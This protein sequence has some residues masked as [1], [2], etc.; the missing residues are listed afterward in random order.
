MNIENI[1]KENS[2]INITVK[3]EEL[4]QFANYIISKTRQE[5]NSIIEEEQKEVLFTREEAGKALGVTLM[6]LYNWK[7][8]GYLEA[9]KIGKAVRYKKSDIDK[10]LM[11]GINSK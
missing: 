8:S 1:I 2:N 10:L 4:M 5:I 3:A 6:T 9:V 11:K 7:K